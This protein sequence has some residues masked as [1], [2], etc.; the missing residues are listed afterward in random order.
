M[1]TLHEEKYKSF[2]IQLQRLNQMY[3][4]KYFIKVVNSFLER[5]S[6]EF[7]FVFEQIQVHLFLYII[8]K[9]H[10]FEVLNNSCSCKC[11]H[12]YFD[13]ISHVHSFVNTTLPN[14]H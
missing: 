10:F 13:D 7:H 6:K 9:N 8:Q 4:E 11:G 3:N 12:G 5:L 2:F 1:F 14:K